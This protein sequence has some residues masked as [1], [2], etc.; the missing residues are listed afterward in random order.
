MNHSGSARYEV[1]SMLKELGN[2]H[3]VCINYDGCVGNVNVTMSEDYL[4]QIL[5]NIIKNS[6]EVSYEGDM[7]DIIV[8]NRN[9][10]MTVIVSDQGR[11]MS[12]ALQLKIFD[13]FFT[14][15]NKNSDSGLGLGLSTTRTIAESMGGFVECSS[16]E[17]KE[18][19]FIID[20]PVNFII[21]KNN[22]S[23]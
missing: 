5:Y 21:E 1:I 4:R 7:V 8:K 13:P 12:E 15:K 2:K 22:C 10:R 11:G 17:G 20:L 23:Q 9:N 19:D 6:I 14:T 3:G 16:E 18:T